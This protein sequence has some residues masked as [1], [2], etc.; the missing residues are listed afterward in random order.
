MTTQL[1]ALVCSALMTNSVES[2]P[3]LAESTSLRVDDAR[4][5]AKIETIY[6]LSPY[7]RADR[8]EVV[9]RDGLAILTGVVAEAV[10]K[11]L[12]GAIAGGVEG[13]RGV[14]NQLLVRSV[15]ALDVSRHYGEVL[16]DGTISKAITSKLGWSR[17]ASGLDVEI[18]TRDGAVTM[19]GYAHDDDCF[20]AATWLA[21]TTRGVRSVDNHIVVSGT[22]IQGSART[23]DDLPD[24]IMSDTGITTRVKYSLLF[25]SSVAGSL[26][27]VGT[28]KGVVTLSGQLESGAER[29]LAIELAQKTA[30]VKSVNADSLHR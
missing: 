5:Q 9:V 6:Q 19:S 15:P 30:G 28:E 3:A 21:G 11:E 23:G 1:L 16:D 8:L 10:N 20:N 26:I 2:P 29:A 12:A 24:A 25:S 13:V 17:Y 14:D 18:K 22:V 27:R 7:L 4:A